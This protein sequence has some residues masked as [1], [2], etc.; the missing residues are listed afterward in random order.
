MG[1]SALVF[2]IIRSRDYPTSAGL[3]WNHP[4]YIARAIGLSDVTLFAA[5]VVIN[6]VLGV[7]VPNVVLGVLGTVVQR[8]LP[9]LAPL[10]NRVN[11]QPAPQAVLTSGF[12]K[13]W[14]NIV[15]QVRAS[16][17]QLGTLR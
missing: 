7:R 3:W 17:P 1:L 10:L 4:D 5:N 13:L 6:G 8:V 15:E 12:S 16:V 9:L 11:P 14:E 2:H